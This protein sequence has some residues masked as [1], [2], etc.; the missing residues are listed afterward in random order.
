MEEGRV[1]GRAEWKAECRSFSM[2]TTEREEGK[3]GSKMC[4]SPPTAT[5]ML[6]SSAQANA[7]GCEG[8][9]LLPTIGSQHWEAMAKRH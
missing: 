5:P 6:F 1:D 9:G 3:A 8:A 7:F 2:S 4:T